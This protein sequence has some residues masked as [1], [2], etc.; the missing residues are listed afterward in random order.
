MALSTA[1]LHNKVVLITGASG[2]IGAATAR[3]FARAGANVVLAARRLETLKQVEAECVQENKAGGSGQGGHYASLKLDMRV[4][5]Q[6]DAI[7]DALPEWA[8]DVDVLVNN[9]GLVLGVDRVGDISPD[10]VDVM[11]DTN[12]RGLI[13]LTQIFVRRFKQRGSGHI[14][15]LGSIAGREAYPGGS[16]YCATKFAVHA[17]TSAL[18]KELVDTPIRVSNI[19]PG[20]VET[21]FSVTRYRG[22]K[23]AA[24]KV[25]E[26]LDPLTA[27]DI[28]EE[29]IWTA[30]RPAHVN[31]AETLIFPVNQA[32][33]YHVARPNK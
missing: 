11:L 15:N 6:L 20:M 25:Y 18:L 10:E 27:E 28:A 29:I 33:P 22:D 8:R 30:S 32:S 4:R 3:L 21:D 16:I 5:E 26:G 23:S 31:N 1:R 24:D 2:G 7:P 9:A 17:F 12:V 19:Q 14:I 13:H